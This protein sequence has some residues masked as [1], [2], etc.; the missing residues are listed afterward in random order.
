[1]I[2]G[3]AAK[4]I[5]AASFFISAAFSARTLLFL[6]KYVIINVLIIIAVIYGTV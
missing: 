5:F 2:K 6:Q 4:F 1:M 3:H